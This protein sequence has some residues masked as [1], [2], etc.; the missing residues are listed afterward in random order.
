MYLEEVKIDKWTYDSVELAWFNT[1][2]DKYTDS[3]R[4]VRVPRLVLVK[5]NAE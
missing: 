5:C 2:P 4:Q 3:S 1:Q